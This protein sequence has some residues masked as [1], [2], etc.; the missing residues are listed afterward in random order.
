M[1]RTVTLAGV[2]LLEIFSLFL[3]NSPLSF[4]EKRLK[5][6]TSGGIVQEEE[7]IGTSISKRVLV[8]NGQIPHITQIAQTEI[9]PGGI[10][11]EHSHPTMCE[12]FLVIKGTGELLVEGQNISLQEGSFFWFAPQQ[13][14]QIHNTNP[15]ISLRLSYFGVSL[16]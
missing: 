2:V 6:P 1:R 14:H 10:I 13:K 12:V 9:P 4:F 16:E 11:E 3:W 8:R 7:Y 15:T 5:V